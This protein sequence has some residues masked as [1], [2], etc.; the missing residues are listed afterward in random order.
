V[1]NDPGLS[2]PGAGQDQQGALGCFDRFS[3]LRVESFREPA[4]VERGSIGQ[5]E[6]DVQ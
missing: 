2:G 6:D 1:G 3:L 4:H 5:E